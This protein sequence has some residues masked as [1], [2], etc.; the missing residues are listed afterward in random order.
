MDDTNSAP[1]YAADEPALAKHL[2][3]DLRAGLRSVEAG[4]ATKMDAA[5]LADVASIVNAFAA[6]GLLEFAYI[7]PDGVGHED[8]VAVFGIS[9]AAIIDDAPDVV[10]MFGYLDRATEPVP[11]LAYEPDTDGEDQNG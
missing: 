6:A 8:D 9:E 10:S 4:D 1:E 5:H 2:S 3:A 7:P 11:I